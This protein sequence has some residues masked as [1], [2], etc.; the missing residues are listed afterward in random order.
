MKL[1]NENKNKHLCICKATSI[2]KAK[3][4]S[5]LWLIE[6]RL[7]FLLIKHLSTQSIVVSL[8]REPQQNEMHSQKDNLL[9]AT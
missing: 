6:K 3:F 1:H 2:D 4:H 7:P 8:Q 5:S 9:S